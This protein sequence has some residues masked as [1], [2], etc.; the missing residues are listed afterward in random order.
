MD[1]D[2]SIDMQLKDF[3]VIKLLESKKKIIHKSMNNLVDSYCCYHNVPKINDNSRFYPLVWELV[4]V[5]PKIFDFYSMHKTLAGE[6]YS[7]YELNRIAQRIAE[8]TVQIIKDE[9]G[10]DFMSYSGDINEK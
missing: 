9:Y 1:L 4:K 10:T 6:Y 2:R 7:I 5:E 3:G 8:L